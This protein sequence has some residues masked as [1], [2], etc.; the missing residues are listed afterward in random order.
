MAES[1]VE[2]FKMSLY[3]T[4]KGIVVFKIYAQLNDHEKG[5]VYIK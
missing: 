5:F 2:L 4:G 3:N 1:I